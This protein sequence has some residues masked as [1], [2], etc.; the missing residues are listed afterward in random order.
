MNSP[1]RV[2]RAAIIGG[3]IFGVSSAV[4][5]ARRGAQVT[6]VT[7][8]ALA[9]QASGRS[10]SWL[11][12]SRMR[13]PEYHQLRMAGIDRYRTLAAKR[14]GA[15]WLRFDGGLTW[16]A[17]DDTNEIAK[18]YA[19]E[20]SI[21]YD[22]QLLAADQVAAVTPGVDVRAVTR[23]GAIFNPG[24]GW[25][26]L[27]SLINVLVEELSALGGEVVTHAGHASVE[28]TNGRA[29][30]IAT[31]DGR[32]FPADA[33]LLAAGA[34][35]PKIVAEVGLQIADATPISLL[36]K[37]EPIDIALRA[38]LNTPR[39]AVRPTP[40]GSLVLDSAW[41]EEEVIRRPDGTFEVKDATVQG[42]L[43]EASAVL[44]GNPTLVL[45]SY[46]VGPKPIPGDG[47]PVFGELPGISGY[48]VA[49]SH[50]GATLGLIAG[51]LLADEIVTGEPHPLLKTF[52]PSRFK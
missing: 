23:Q 31:A 28:V 13:S 9:S 21:G 44:D 18:V 34:A 17:D 5:L 20:R 38:V 29:T 6:L 39:V 11:N 1:S 33:V 48:H 43:A 51:E 50:S 45:D 32:R 40:T 30:G 14:P 2:S 27:P 47:E 46:G 19:H 41:S 12:S 4:Q 25:V 24:E 52:R 36:V 37:T 3:G 8:G 49:F 22:A 15:A 26:D 35:V 42:L 16:D 7:E 10:L